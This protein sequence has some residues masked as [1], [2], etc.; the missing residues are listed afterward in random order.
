MPTHFLFLC[1][2]NYKTELVTLSTSHGFFSSFDLLL[3]YSF[4]LNNNNNSNKNGEKKIMETK[5]YV[6]AVNVKSAQY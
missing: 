6:N 2:Y 5:S 3:Q 1:C 4:F